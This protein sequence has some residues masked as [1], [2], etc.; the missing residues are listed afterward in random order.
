M[1]A[2]GT[3]EQLRGPQ[4]PPSDRTFPAGTR[5]RFRVAGESPIGTCL[6][7][8]RTYRVDILM[9]RFDNGAEMLLNSE[10]LEAA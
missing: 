3:I 1:M 9:V 7:P 6:G 2:V 10:I 8:Y 4:R 5:L